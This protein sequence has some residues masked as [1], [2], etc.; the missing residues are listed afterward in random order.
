MFKLLSKISDWVRGVK[1]SA[2]IRSDQL[3]KEWFSRQPGLAGVA[4]HD[5]NAETIATVFQAITLLSGD[6]AKLPIHVYKDGDNGRQRDSGSSLERLLRR[7]PSRDMSAIFWKRKGARDVLIYG[8]SYFLIVRDQQLRPIELIP[9]DP[10]NTRPQRDKSGRLFYEWRETPSVAWRPYP[11]ADILHWRGLSKDGILGI[12]IIDQARESLGLTKAAENFGATFFGNGSVSSGIIEHPGAMDEETVAKTRRQWEKMHSRESAHKVAILQG[13]VK[14]VPL[15][16]PPEQAQFL[17]TRQFQRQEVASWF[18]LPPHKL[19]DSSQTSYSSLEQ[20]NQSYLD[21]SLEPLLCALE[22]EMWD[23]LLLER[24]KKAGYEIE[25]L[26]QALLKPD[27]KTRTEI[28]VLRVS[29]GLATVNEWR[30]EENLPP[31]DG[32]DV[33]RVPLNT[34]PATKDPSA[35]TNQPPPGKQKQK[36]KA[37]Q[38]QPLTSAIDKGP[39]RRL[40]ESAIA[41]KIRWEV[42]AVTRLAR[43]PETFSDELDKFYAD[44]RGR[45]IESLAPMTRFALETIYNG[46]PMGDLPAAVD[47]YIAESKQLLENSR[48]SVGEVMADWQFRAAVVASEIIV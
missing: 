26:R 45:M 37:K 25:F 48:G 32:G 42:N 47:R 28:G 2:A 9:L 27:T 33:I 16:I 24:E 31:V 17:A 41:S 34:A 11:A 35:A 1:A 13:G 21:S 19:G 6:A 14:F 12:G 46:A 44:H 29:N 22:E 3:F 10:T 18:N 23:K 43:K 20:Q 4:I 39:F 15:T 30:D 36:K 8:N 40:V 38:S 7:K 5:C